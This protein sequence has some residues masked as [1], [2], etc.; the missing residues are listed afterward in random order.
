VVGLKMSCAVHLPKT[1]RT[2]LFLLGAISLCG[3]LPTKAMANGFC[4][5]DCQWPSHDLSINGPTTHS[6]LDT[7]SVYR[8]AF[9]PNNTLKAYSINHT[10]QFV[11]DGGPLLAKLL[12]LSFSH[13]SIYTDTQELLNKATAYLE[14]SQQLPI[15][16]QFNLAPNTVQLQVYFSF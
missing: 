8:I 12:T 16:Y 10:T 4:G 11:L 9:E 6:I 7:F 13:L 3:A 14:A 2:L 5:W 15:H 1:W